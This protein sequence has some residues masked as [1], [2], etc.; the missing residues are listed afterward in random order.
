MSD[1]LFRGSLAQVDP[2]VAALIRYEHER[3]IRKLILIPSES[4]A[5]AAVREALG[6]VFQNLYAEGYP[7]ERTR[8]QTEAELLDYE[9]QLGFHRRYGDQRYYKGT[10]YANIIEALARRR[11]AEAFATP[12]IP[13]ERIFVN[14]QPLS[15]APANSAVYEALLQPGDTVMG[16]SLIHGGH[17]THGSPV[18]R[19]GKHYRIVWYTVDP[20]TELL[21]YDQIRDLA[22][23]HRPKMIIAGYTSYPW[24][25]DWKR[26]R[27]IADEVGAY[28]L[29]DIAHTAGM[30]IAGAYPNPLGYAHVITFTTHKTIM[31]PRGACI[32]TTD[33]ELAKKID[34]AVFPGEQ[35]GPHVNVFAAL[36]VAFKL[37]RTEPFRQL[38]HQIVRNAQAMARRLAERGLRIPYGGTNTHLLLVDCKSVRGPD[39]TPLMGDPAARVLDLAGIVVNRNTIPGDTGA[40]A[41][42]GIRLGTPWITQRGFR[43]L[44]VEALAD[45]IADILW[46]CRPHRYYVGRDLVYRTKVEFDVLEEAKL[47][48]A[49]LAA[50]AGIDVELPK[51]GYP[52]YWFI[53]DRLPAAEGKAVLEIRGDRAAEFI[54]AVLTQ[55]VAAL[56]IGHGAP[57]FILEADGRVMSS[58][59]VIRDSSNAFRLVIPEEH[60]G[61]VAAWLRDLSDGYVRFDEDIWAKLHGP[62]R[63]REIPAEDPQAVSARSMACF[64]KDLAEAA[65]VAPYKPFFIGYRAVDEMYRDYLRP[66]PAFS[67]SEPEGAPLQRTSLYELHRELGA[68]MVPFAGWEMPAWYTSVSEE[69]RAVRTAA[70]LF[71]VS[72]MGILEVSGPGARVFLEQVTTNDVMGL[73][74]GES[75]YTYLLDPEGHVLDDLIIYTLSSD[76]YLLVVNA[77]NN[78]RDWAW[79]NAVARGE[80][81]IDCDRPWA[82]IADEVTLRDLRDRRWGEE[83]RVDIALQGPQALNIL[84]RMVDGPT[85][86]RLAALQRGQVMTVEIHGFDLILAR[87]GYTGERVGY[88]L[89][90]HPDRALALFELLLDVGKPLGLRPCG[91]GARDGTRTEAGLPLYGHELAGPFDLS[92]GD[93]GFGSFVKV[94]KPFFIGR[95]AYMAREA[96]RTMEV[97]RF[98]ISEKGMRLPKL[99]DAVV[100]RWGRVIGYVTSCALDTEGFL[101]GMAWIERSYQAEGTPIGIVVGSAAAPERPKVGDR[102][103][104]PIPAQVVSRFMSR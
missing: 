54:E 71:D 27:E 1:F 25:P 104:V 55:R 34:R 6:S 22:R 101:T 17:L 62:L 93:A 47:R 85:Q 61:R 74:V 11:C 59:Y 40:G 28:L 9:E 38:Q 18:N 51:S 82:V 64:P 67:Y 29:A 5:P 13:P 58:A 94:Y 100:D 7:H 77:A 15:G 44:E 16:L 36:A 48:V 84:R 95:K 98:R 10:E 78:D 76:R 49:E 2:E 12:E 3:Q 57:A 26:F 56:K 91:L 43:E 8:T 83:C 20:Q 35:G 4:Y 52:H 53:T 103:N 60:A 23:Q 89:F 21:N 19:S 46:A 30:A 32:L 70:G 68:K 79:L 37:A 66:L 99:G 69:H 63:V 73:K 33:P 86:E 31:G 14:V 90:V 81:Q 41:A 39:G 72:H 96:K 50:R 88:E 75:Q 80:V 102:L 65:A 92:P 45:I 24:A 42:S 97:V 87:T